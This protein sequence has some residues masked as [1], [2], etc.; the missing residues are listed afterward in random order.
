MLKT[1]G[2]ILEELHQYASPADKLSRL[3]KQGKY[4]PIVKG[5]YETN[6]TVPGYL[7]AGSIYGPSY[8]SFEFALAYYGLI[9]EAVYTFTSATLKKKKKKIFK[10]AFGVFTYRDI[11]APAYSYGVNIRVEGAYSYI[12][13]S[14]E[15]ALCDQLYKVEGIKNYQELGHLLLDDLRIDEQ[16]LQKLN[17]DDVSVLAQKYGSTNVRKLSRWL[18]KR[19][20]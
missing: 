1:T 15:K 6:H 3:V 7:L 16:E 20:T 11:P 2:M 12:I 17:V 10:T 8:L 5:L 4:I 13:A 19:V 14:P 9:P 18:E